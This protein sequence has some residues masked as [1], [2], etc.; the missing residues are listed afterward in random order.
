MVGASPT[1]D[2]WILP[3]ARSGPTASPGEEVE[4][5]V[6]ASGDEDEECDAPLLGRLATG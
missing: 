3:R 5:E 2:R 1:A 4:D 6:V